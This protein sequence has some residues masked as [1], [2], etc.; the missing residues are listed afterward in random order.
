MPF[1][2]PHPLSHACCRTTVGIGVSETIGGDC[3]VQSSASHFNTWLT[4]LK[5]IASFLISLNT[6]HD[7]AQ[8]LEC[9]EVIIDNS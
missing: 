7:F 6:K 4:N 2:V 8:L 9:S 1:R 3:A 5:S